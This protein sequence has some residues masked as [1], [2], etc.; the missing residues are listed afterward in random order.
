MR[1]PSGPHPAR[2]IGFGAGDYAFNLFWQ[3]ITLYLLFFYTD[4]LGLTPEAAGL[5][6]MVGAI[7]DGL[8]DLAIGITADRWRLRYR[9]IIAWW[10]APLALSFALLFQR[11]AG[12]AE[13][14]LATVMATHVAFRIL[15]ALVNLPYA[16]WSTRVSIHARDRTLMSGSRMTFGALGA[17]TVAWAMPAGGGDYAAVAMLLAGVAAMI[18]WL[19]VWRIPE[20]IPTASSLSAGHSLMRDLAAIAH[21]R[22]F[23]MLCAA[24]FCATMAAAIIGHSVL[25]YFAH[26][27][28]DAVA[29]KR[30]LA[31]MAVIGTLAVPLWTLIALRWS[32]QASWLAAACL[33]LVALAALPLWPGAPDVPVSITVLA[34]VQVALSGFHLAAWAML[35]MAVDHGVAHTGVR[36]EATAFSLFML[37]QKIGLGLAALLLG[38]AYAMGGYAGGV[39]DAAGRDVIAWV[40]I[41]GPAVMIAAGGAIMMLAP[42]RG[43]VDQA[44]VNMSDTPS[45]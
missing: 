25:Y 6:M 43:P 14:L 35:P 28:L 29:G 37:V 26:V 16:A 5:V 7:A 39:P 44:S 17:V 3:T 30:A 23:L 21:N 19:V 24:T 40:M 2:A 11:P 9:R 20:T 42:L 15:Y 8:T 12:G 32:A 22:A 27:L 45:A 31:V 34:L 41:A 13:W 33:A 10:A 4:A 36:V 38:L 1:D 18:L